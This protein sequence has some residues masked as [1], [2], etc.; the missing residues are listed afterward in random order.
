MEK[1]LLLNKPLA[2]GD[3]GSDVRRVQEWLC[4]NGNATAIDGDYGPATEAAVRLFQRGKNITVDG[5]VGPGTWE[6]LTA[7]MRAALR[8]IATE[9]RSVVIKTASGEHRVELPVACYEA[10]RDKLPGDALRET[11]DPVS[12]YAAGHLAQ[13]PREA[14]GQNRGPWV[15]LYCAGQH[16]PWCAGFASFVLR[17]AYNGKPPI[18]GS[19]SCD[20]LSKQATTAGLFVSGNAALAMAKHGNF[21]PAGSVFLIRS[22]PVDWTHTGIVTR[23]TASIIYTIEGNTNDEGSREGYEVAART[24]KISNATDFI[25][26]KPV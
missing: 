15:R 22:K 1:E 2:H 19:L 18:T 26:F 10:L 5:I 16:A 20:V 25:V 23:A 17:Q 14:G 12:A 24:R 3:K 6:A 9:G 21:I 7:S 13:H 11:T 8:P 4:L